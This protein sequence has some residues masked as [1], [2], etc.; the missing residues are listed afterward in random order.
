ML[1]FLNTK[2]STLAGI[3]VLLVITGAVGVM[4]CYQM[5]QVLTIRYEPIEFRT[6]E[7]PL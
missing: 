4:I 7:E 3:I 2:I 5:Y 6:L 1:G